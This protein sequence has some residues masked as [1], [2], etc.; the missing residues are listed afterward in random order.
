MVSTS[1]NEGPIHFELP[2]RDLDRDRYS[3]HFPVS[4]D[5][6]KPTESGRVGS[7]RRRYFRRRRRRYSSTISTAP[8]TVATS[9]AGVPRNSASP[10]KAR[11]SNRRTTLPKRRSS[12]KRV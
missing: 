1:K 3:D 10:S 9:S 2:S 6:E 12:G 5:L 7:Q 8:M 11:T 4:V